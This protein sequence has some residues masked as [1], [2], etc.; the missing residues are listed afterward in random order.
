[1][2]RES[3]EGVFVYLYS[4][5]D[6]LF[7]YNT[8]PFTPYDVMKHNNSNLHKSLAISCARPGPSVVGKFAP[9]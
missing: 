3:A 8:H 7:I 5:F 1:M 4:F 9:S 2:V 6:G